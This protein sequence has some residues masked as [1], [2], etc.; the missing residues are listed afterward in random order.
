MSSIAGFIS[1]QQLRNSDGNEGVCPS[2]ADCR[3]Q[4]RVYNPG[5]RETVDL[6]LCVNHGNVVRELK[7]VLCPCVH[8]REEHHVQR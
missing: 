8:R 1:T 2:A 5:V 7:T 6:Y 4:K 3:Y